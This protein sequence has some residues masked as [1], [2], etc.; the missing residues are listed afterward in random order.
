MILPHGCGAPPGAAPTGTKIG[1]S[2]ALRQPLPAVLAF[3]RIETR[4]AV[5]PAVAFR[6]TGRAIQDDPHPLERDQ[7][8]GDHLIEQRQQCLDPVLG[9][10]DLDDDLETLTLL[11]QGRYTVAAAYSVG[12]VAACAAGIVAGIAAATFLQR[13]RP[14]RA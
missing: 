9:F 6:D 10:N 2:R 11:Q 12:S 3:V 13:Q 7:P 4:N 14:R 5:L 8:T 1:R